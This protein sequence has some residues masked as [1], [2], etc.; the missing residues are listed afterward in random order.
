MSSHSWTHAQQAFR[1][2][3]DWFVSVTPAASGREVDPGVGEWTVRDLVGHTSRALST[4]ETYLDKPVAVIDV[5][6]PVDYFR[7]ALASTGDSAAVAQRGRDA[8]AALGADPV[9][10]IEEIA[11]P[12]PVR[13]TPTILSAMTRRRG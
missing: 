7:L 8:G 4:V 6:S 1:E 5:S 10:A 2:A 3:T 12:S 13:W 11:A 9:A